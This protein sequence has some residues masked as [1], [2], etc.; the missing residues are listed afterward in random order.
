MKS[1]KSALIICIVVTLMN[2]VLFANAEV[3]TPIYEWKFVSADV[4]GGFATVFGER[5][6][7]LVEERSEGR[8][9]IDVYPFGVLGAERDLVEL[10]QLGEIELGGVSYGWLGGFVPQVNVF[11]LQY[12]WPKDNSAEVLREVFKNGKAVQLLDEKF[13]AKGM[14]LLAALGNGWQYITS[15]MPIHSPEDVKGLKHRVMATPILISSYNAYGF[16]SQS[17]DYSEIYVALQNKLIDTQVNPITGIYDMRFYE[18]QDY[19]T[20]IWNEMFIKLPVINRD[21]YDSLPKDLQQIVIESA[22]DLVGPM[23]EWDTQQ[24][25]ASR[26]KIMKEK[27]TFTFYELTDEEMV[28][29]RDMAW[30]KDGPLDAYLKVSG[31]GGK[32]ILDALLA[33]VEAAVKTVQNQ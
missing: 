30:G 7:N 18:V 15:N 8:I 6:A 14:H 20:C 23:D 29:F 16:N 33:D 27:P 25:A 24:K 12:I 17:L 31:E 26:D 11:A 5:F 3:Q 10:V 13:R 4:A 1:F 21:V 9:K 32:E 19:A 28:P 22:L 2:F